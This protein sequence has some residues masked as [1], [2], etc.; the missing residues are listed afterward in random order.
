[1]N[2]PNAPKHQGRNEQ[3]ASLNTGQTAPI[4]SDMYIDS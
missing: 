2:P 3:N 1:M 4:G